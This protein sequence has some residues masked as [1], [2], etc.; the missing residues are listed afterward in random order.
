ME[1]HSYIEKL[2]CAL[3]LKRKIVGVKFIFTRDEF[4]NMDIEQLQG[5]ASY[6]YM[7]KMASEGRMFKA[8]NENFRCNSS[9]RA[10]GMRQKSEKAIAGREYFSYGLY[11]SLSRAKQVQSDVTY[12]NHSIYGIA[13]MPIKEF[14]CN[15]DVVIIMA[16]SYQAMRLVQGYT[17]GNGFAKNIRLCGNQGVCSEC[18]AVPYENNDINIS[19]LCANTRFACEW[20]DCEMGVGMPFNLFESVAKGVLRTLNPVEPDY[21][22]EDIAKR[23]EVSNEDIELEIGKNYYESSVGY[24][25]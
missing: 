7:V 9:A 18:T 17:Y 4:E 23:S 22:K 13:I 16:D 19:M 6:C 12:I 3:G 11:D 5:A 21:K 15:P 25:V 1:G 8:G 2:Y 24:I 10:L 20:E 14:E